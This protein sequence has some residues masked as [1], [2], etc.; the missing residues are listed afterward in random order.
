MHTKPSR[1][2]FVC[3][4]RHHI[5]GPLTHTR[6]YLGD[7]GNKHLPVASGS[8]FVA[9]QIKTLPEDQIFVCLNTHRGTVHLRVAETLDLKCLQVFYVGEQNLQLFL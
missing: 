9:V 4:K 1:V 3:F 8:H 2:I 5:G 7:R 6:S